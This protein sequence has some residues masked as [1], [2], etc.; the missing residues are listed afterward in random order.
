MGKGDKK[1]RRGK[2][3]AGSYGK[4]RPRKSSKSFAASEEK[5]KK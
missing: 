4:R 5:S 1:S 2:I 3:N